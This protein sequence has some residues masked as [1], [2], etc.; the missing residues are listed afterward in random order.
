MDLVT[1]DIGFFQSHLYF[2]KLSLQSP[3]NNFDFSNT[4]RKA[5][6]ENLVPMVESCKIQRSN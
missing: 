2:L 5:L 3:E 1:N 6:G 4:E